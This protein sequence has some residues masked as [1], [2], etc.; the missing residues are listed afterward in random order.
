LTREGTRIVDYQYLKNGVKLPEKCP[1][2]GY[3]CSRDKCWR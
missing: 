3:G 2:S 1:L